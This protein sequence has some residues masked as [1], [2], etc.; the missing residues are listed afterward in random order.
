MVDS[1]SSWGS[2]VHML[3]PVTSSVIN[4]YYDIVQLLSYD[5]LERKNNHLLLFL[6]V[7]FP[8]SVNLVNYSPSAAVL[9]I[10]LRNTGL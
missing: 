1:E 3:H 8:S 4:Q 2:N 7:T 10:M 9:F 5:G 6:P